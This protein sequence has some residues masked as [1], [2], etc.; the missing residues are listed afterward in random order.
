MCVY[1]CVTHMCI[2]ICVY[3][4]IHTHIYT[5]ICLHNIHNLLVMFKDIFSLC[6]ALIEPNIIMDIGMQ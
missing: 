4:Y 2:Y 3:I 5:E 6:L 1:M